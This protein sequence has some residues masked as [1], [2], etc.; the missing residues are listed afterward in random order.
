MDVHPTKNVSIGIDPYPFWEFAPGVPGEVSLDAELRKSSDTWGC[1]H[2]TA[3]P[4]IWRG[5]ANFARK[6]Q[7]KPLGRHSFGI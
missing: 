5:R 2:R 6:L 3:G 1:G 4:E 7:T